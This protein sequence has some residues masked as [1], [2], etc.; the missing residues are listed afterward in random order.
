MV[1]WQR[2]AE[3]DGPRDPEGENVRGRVGC[4][5]QRLALWRLLCARK[6]TRTLPPFCL[7]FMNMHVVFSA[8]RALS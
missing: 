3:S 6:Y 7:W 1:A 4:R 8:E 5:Q 2:R